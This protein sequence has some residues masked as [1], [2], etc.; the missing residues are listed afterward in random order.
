MRLMIIRKMRCNA[1]TCPQRS[2]IAA[3]QWGLCMPGIR[4]RKDVQVAARAGC[5]ISAIMT[6]GHIGREL[7][8]RGA[9]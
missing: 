2:F 3:T 5:G 7:G 9:R 1:L 8:K 4:E 6:E